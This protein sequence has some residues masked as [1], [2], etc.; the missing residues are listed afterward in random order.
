MISIDRA[1]FGVQERQGDRQKEQ[2]RVND[3]AHNRAKDLESV[4]GYRKLM[5]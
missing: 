2:A 5:I 3:D 4:R 1:G